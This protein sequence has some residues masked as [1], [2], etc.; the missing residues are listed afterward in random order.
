MKPLKMSL[1]L[2]IILFGM[3]ACDK[4]ESP[5]STT[6]P[7]TGGG[8]TSSGASILGGAINILK[9]TYVTPTASNQNRFLFSV[10]FLN[11]N[12]LVPPQPIVLYDA[13]IVTVNGITLAKDYS[14]LPD[15]SYFDSTFQVVGPNFTLNAAGSSTIPAVQLTYNQGLPNLGDTSNIPS[16]I[17]K[18][19]GC[20]FTFTNITNADSIN[21]YLPNGASTT[22]DISKLP[23]NNGVS[24]N[25]TATQLSSAFGTYTTTNQSARITLSKLVRVV[26]SGREYQWVFRDIYYKQK[27]KLQ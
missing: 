3:M 8:S 25:I 19:L 22:I 17:T 13:G 23:V 6:P 24:F 4:K 7:S 9:E 26:V 11:Y 18:S 15:I 12:L 5:V 27:I 14:E 21:F 10:S 20:S 16:V 1:I 2:A